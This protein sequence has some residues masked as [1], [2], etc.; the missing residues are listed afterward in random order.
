MARSAALNPAS[1]PFFP[2]NRST[3]DDVLGGISLGQRQSVR[4]EQDRSS[5]SSISISPTEY[6]SV[7]SSPSPPRIEELANGSTISRPSPPPSNEG[8]RRSPTFRQVDA[9]RPYPG[10]E[11]RIQREVSMLGSLESLPEGEDVQTTPGPGPEPTSRGLG[12]FTLQQ[13]KERISTPPVP[14]NNNNNNASYAAAGFTSSSPASS[15]DSGSQFAP[16]VDFQPQS[17]EAQLRASPFLHDMLDRLVRC[18]F[19]TR[20]I[21][22]DLGYMHRKVNLLVER[23]LGIG[24]PPEFKFPFASSNGP[25]FSPRPSRG[26]IAPNQPAPSDDITTIS[27]RLNTLT[28]SVGQLLALQTRQ[29]QSSGLAGLSMMSSGNGSMEVNPSMNSTPSMLSHGL[30]PNRT[31]MRPSPR[32]PNPPMRTWSTGTLDLPVR[33]SDI[34]VGR[35]DSALRD[36]RRSVS[37]LLRRDSSSVSLLLSFPRIAFSLICDRW[38]TLKEIIGAVVIRVH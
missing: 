8:S 37:G 30:P 13:G 28:S 15:L 7:K 18:E 27:Q 26:N 35:Q 29:I 2:G 3:D 25:T 36:K 6:R 21:Q 23:S 5:S 38:W 34:N 12:F 31:D 22:R 10:I 33:S 16:S 9:N 14:I 4:H 32:I 11:N 17:F 1:M 24:S 19:S 20:E